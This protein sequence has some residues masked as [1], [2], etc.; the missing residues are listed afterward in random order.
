MAAF[1]LPNQV[2]DSKGNQ[3]ATSHKGECISN[4]AVD[5]HAA[6]DHQHSERSRAQN[7]TC[8]GETSHGERFRFG[9]TLSSGRDNKRK[10]VRWNHS[11]QKSDGESRGQ[12]SYENNIIHRRAGPLVLKD[13]AAAP[14]AN[15]GNQ[16][17]KRAEGADDRGTGWQIPP[18]GQE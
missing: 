1:H 14:E 18:V 11:V 8:S 16:N 15:Q 17:Q 3:H 13:K 7:M 12:Q 4:S 2:E 5:R 9:P 6:P 10:P